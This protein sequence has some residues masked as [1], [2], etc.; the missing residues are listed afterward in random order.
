MKHSLVLLLLISLSLSADAQRRRKQPAPGEWEPPKEFPG[1]ADSTLSEMVRMMSTE[2]YK[3]DTLFKP[4]FNKMFPSEDLHSMACY[5]G[6]AVRVV[7]V[8]QQ[9]PGSFYFTVSSKGKDAPTS[10]LD[11]L[12][13]GGREYLYATSVVSFQSGYDPSDKKCFHV[14]AR[15]GYDRS[16]PVYLFILTKYQ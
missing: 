14:G 9:R 5:S 8:M 7:A 2:G 1:I 13:A 15:D 3:L 6:R 11:T 10:K 12:K 16:L 4:D